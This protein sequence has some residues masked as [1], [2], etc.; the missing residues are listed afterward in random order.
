[1]I[2]K[3]IFSKITAV[4]CIC[5]AALIIFY[6]DTVSGAVRHGINLCVSVLIPSLFPFMFI[7]SFLV[8]SGSAAELGNNSGKLFGKI[9]GLPRCAIGVIIISLLGGYPAG[10]Q[11]VSGLYE[12]GGLSKKDCEKLMCF[13]VCAG[14]AFLCEVLGR[15]CF[16][17]FRAGLVLILAQTFSTLLLGF[18]VCFFNKDK[19]ESISL[20]TAPKGQKKTPLSEAFVSS[21]NEAADVML[22]VCA[23]V[24]IFTVLIGLLDVTGFSLVFE[25]L[26]FSLFKNEPLSKSLLYAL[27]E[28]SAGCMSAAPAGIPFTAFGALFGGFCV[29]FQIFSITSSIGINKLKFIIFRFVHGLC[30]AA[31]SALLLKF[32]KI[33]AACAATT[34]TIKIAAPSAGGAVSLVILCLVFLLS[35]DPAPVSRTK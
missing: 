9:T 18:T 23:Y 33:E 2:K 6:S 8:K 22:R 1:M 5:T 29:H 34:G 35:R 12:K 30:A 21:V 14:P 10:A 4:L 28:T 27:S 3:Q 31:V 11:T 25:R 24:V 26:I 16:N 13:C 7:S 32:I 20:N 17:S 15:I 19:G